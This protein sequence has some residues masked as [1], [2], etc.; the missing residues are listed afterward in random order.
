MLTLL[1]HQ[2]IKMIRTYT[3]YKGGL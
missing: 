1:Q 3:M 2:P